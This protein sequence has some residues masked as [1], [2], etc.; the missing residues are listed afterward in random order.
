MTGLQESIKS[1]QESADRIVLIVA[2]LSERTVRW[3]PAPEVWSI[4]EILSHLEEAVPYWAKEIQRVVARPGVEWGRNHE[5]EVRLAAVAAASQRGVKDVL[6]GFQTGVQR[7]VVELTKL[8]DEDLIIES[9]SR[10]PRFGIKS[11]SFVLDHLLVTHLRGHLGQIE[12]NV[13]QCAG[14]PPDRAQP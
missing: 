13:E 9:P 2:N 10:N 8:R 11:M 4:L 3:K 12:R 5:N 6:A 1:M 14:A 7:A